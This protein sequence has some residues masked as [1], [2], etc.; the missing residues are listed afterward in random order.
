M[1][2]KKLSPIE[3]LSY[4]EA[5]AELEEIVRRL[6]NGQETLEESMTAFERGQALIQHCSTLLE[7][8][9]LRVRTLTGENIELNEGQET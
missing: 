7:A 5:L 6:E 9:T 4:E 2:D 8:A 1:T 3:S